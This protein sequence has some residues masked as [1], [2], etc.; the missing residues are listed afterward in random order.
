VLAFFGPTQVIV[1][2]RVEESNWRKQ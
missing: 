2:K 1:K